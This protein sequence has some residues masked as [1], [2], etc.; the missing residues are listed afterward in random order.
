MAQLNPTT[1]PFDASHSHWYCDWNVLQ[2]QHVF[3]KKS[4]SFRSSQAEEELPNVQNMYSDYSSTN[5]CD[6][7]AAMIYHIQER[8]LFY[9][10]VVDQEDDSSFRSE[11]V[12]SQPT[13][14]FFKNETQLNV[15]QYQLVVDST[16]DDT[17]NDSF[18]IKSLN[19]NRE[20]HVNKSIITQHCKVFES[21]LKSGMIESR[22]NVTTVECASFHDFEMMI[23]FIHLGS[24]GVPDCEFVSVDK[25]PN[26]IRL[27]DLIG[28]LRIADEYQV[29]SLTRAISKVLNQYCALPVAFSAVDLSEDCKT[30]IFPSASTV[31][32]TNIDCV[33]SLPI[34]HQESLTTK[35]MDKKYNEITTKSELGQL[36]KLKCPFVKETDYFCHLFILSPCNIFFKTIGK[37]PFDLFKSIV[38]AWKLHIEELKTNDDTSILQTVFLWM[39]QD[40]EARYVDACSL[41]R[42]Y[43]NLCNCTDHLYHIVYEGFINFGDSNQFKECRDELQDLLVKVLLRSHGRY[44]ESKW[45]QEDLD[46]SK[47][48]E[49]MAKGKKN[50]KLTCALLGLDESGKT[51]IMYKMKLGE[52]VLTVPTSGIVTETI[53]YRN[54]DVVMTEVGGTLKDSLLWKDHCKQIDALIFVVNSNDGDRLPLATEYLTHIISEL[55]TQCPVLV[56]ANMQD[57]PSAKSVSSICD[58]MMLSKLCHSRAWFIQATCTISGDGL[59]EGIEWLA[60]NQSHHVHIPYFG[61]LSSSA[62]EYSVS[63]NAL[64]EKLE[65]PQF[66]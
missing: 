32:A 7:N 21:M 49:N 63:G 58:E 2:R 30:L 42:D 44:P 29:E 34:Y 37:M 48:I 1:T 26:V 10:R 35:E 57:L 43:I 66:N 53:S 25:T 55:P 62:F 5:E 15:V 23:Q 65:I 11:I 46:H 61:S 16:N 31:I 38:I 50:I 22:T 19:T 64:V 59:Y 4:K 51:T 33:I 8:L 60:N 54:V 17:I 14:K 13:L 9:L 20:L 36:A 18:I 47:L 27:K 24:L 39:I 6:V 28:L 56:Y 52:V 45:K 3:P 40:C 41:I 12:S